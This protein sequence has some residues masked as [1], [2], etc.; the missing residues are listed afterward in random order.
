VH[1]C[2]RESVTISSA[3]GKGILVKCKNIQEDW[4]GHATFTNKLQLEH[5]HSKGALPPHLRGLQ[6]SISMSTM[7]REGECS[8]ARGHGEIVASKKEVKNAFVK[9]NLEAKGTSIHEVK[10]L[11]DL[12]LIVASVDVQT[13][14]ENK[15]STQTNLVF[16]QS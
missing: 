3:F 4:V 11:V 7:F 15:T 10:E 12:E 14:I 8:L 1:Q 16:V 2:P 5:T 13:M 6:S 9:A